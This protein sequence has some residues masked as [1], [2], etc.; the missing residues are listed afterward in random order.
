MKI[1]DIPGGLRLDVA[2][3]KPTLRLETTRFARMRMTADGEPL[4][5]ARMERCYAGVWV[6]RAKAKQLAIARPIRAAEARDGRSMEAWM[7]W[8]AGELQSGTSPLTPGEWCMSSMRQAKPSLR[9]RIRTPVLD[10]YFSNSEEG[11]PGPAYGALEAMNTP[12]VHYEDWGIN[13]SGGVLPLRDASTE[14]SGRIKSWRKHAR[15]GTLPPVLMWWIAAL[16][17]HVVLD[18]HDRLSAAVA[19]GV[20]P[21]LITLWQPLEMPIDQD[22]AARKRFHESYDRAFA[23]GGLS[24]EQ[25]KRLNEAM[26][27]WHKDKWMRST[28]TAKASPGLDA[29]WEPEVLAA[30]DGEDV[31]ELLK[32]DVR[33]RRR[34]E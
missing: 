33:E 22:V 9:D 17:A 20:S 24:P 3:S 21:R 10:V 16:D 8:F 26:I 12:R 2:T 18:G 23:S 1:A 28:T 15:G 6:L 31:S 29:A 13:G 32:V 7:R 25:R 27:G 30:A 11:N 19:E 34:A 14:D 4:F 5:W